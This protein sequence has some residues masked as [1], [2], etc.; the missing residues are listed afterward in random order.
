MSRMQVLCGPEADFWRRCVDGKGGEGQAAA[1]SLTLPR[2]C[3]GPCLSR[4]REGSSP[5][6]RAV[7]SPSPHAGEGPFQ[8]SAAS[9]PLSRLRERV[10]ARALSHPQHVHHANR[11]PAGRPATHSAARTAPVGEGAAVEGAVGQRDVLGRRR[12]RSACARPP[13]GRRAARR[14][15]SRRSCARR[16][17]RP[18]RFPCTASSSTPRPCATARPSADRGAGGRVDL[19]AVVHLDDLGVVGVGRQGGAHPLG[20]RQHQVDAGGEV[21][22]VDDRRCARAAA[23]TAASSAAERP[24]VPSTQALAGRRQRRRVG[25]RGGGMGEIDAPRRPPRRAPRCRGSACTPWSA[26][27]PGR[28]MPPTSVAPAAATSSTSSAPHPAGDAGDSDARGHVR[29]FARRLAARPAPPTL[30]T[31]A[32]R[33]LV[34][35][36]APPAPGPRR[37]WGGTAPRMFNQTPIPRA[38]SPALGV[39]DQE[40]GN[41]LSRAPGR[42]RAPWRR[43]PRAPGCR[44]RRRRP[45]TPPAARAGGGSGF[46]GSRPATWI[47]M[48]PR[49]CAARSTVKPLPRRR[50]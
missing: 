47:S 33:P 8:P 48:S 25:G 49:C 34:G 13:P 29:D 21:R 2:R 23:A 3:V 5:A 16:C 45:R 44:V 10:G 7:A 42:I 12:R 35:R 46:G 30:A 28:S 50:N 22:R 31:V 17:A 32:A 37:R 24:E 20:E 9:H 14:S 11:A 39:A 41:R 15:R 40:L 1:A 43:T 4:T 38:G 26:A 36:T 6:D 18:G 19:L 27:A